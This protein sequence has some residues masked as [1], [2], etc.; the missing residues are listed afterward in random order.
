MATA[1]KDVGSF[2]FPFAIGA[3]EIAV[4]LGFA[5]ATGMGALGFGFHRRDE[6][7][8]HSTRPASLPQNALQLEYNCEE[9]I[10]CQYIS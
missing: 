7:T 1:A 5:M 10:P 9:Y 8:L 6:S 4:G 3:A 2:C